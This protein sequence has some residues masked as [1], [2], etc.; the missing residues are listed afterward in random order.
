MFRGGVV[1]HPRYPGVRV[2]GSGLNLTH[3]YHGQLSYLFFLLRDLGYVSKIYRGIV[4]G[5]A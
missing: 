2:F 5:A 1:H 3:L 4:P